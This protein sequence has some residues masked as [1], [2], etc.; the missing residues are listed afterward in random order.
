MNR[1]VPFTSPAEQR[2]AIPD[3]IAHL[4]AGGLIACPTET[5]YGFG[6]ALR[7]RALERLAGVKRRTAGKPFLLLIP[8]AL[9]LA[10]VEWT[11][12]ATALAAAFWPG[13]LTLALR[14]KPGAFPAPVVSADGTVAVRATSHTGM[15]MLLAAMAEPITSTSA[16]APGGTPARSIAQAGALLGQLVDAPAVLLLDGGTLPPSRPS[17]I[18]DASVRPPRLVR[19]GA[20]HSDELAEIV[21]GI[22]IPEP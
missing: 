8:D 14:A 22:G 5:V 15:R 12:E 18:V 19:E 10:G 1:L 4:R 3:V 21:H 6:C 20:I 11:D 9:A 16:N 17:T 7:D 2:A 13:P